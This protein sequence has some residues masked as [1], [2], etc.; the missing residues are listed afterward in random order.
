MSAMKKYIVL[1]SLF[2]L[3]FLLGG[4]RE[5]VFEEEVAVDDFSVDH[6]FSL[7]EG[8]STY[9]IELRV[10][11]DV[12]MGYKKRIGDR[13][14]GDI[15]SPSGKKY[16]RSKAMSFPTKD[17]V[18]SSKVTLLSFSDIAYEEG[19]FNLHVEKKAT[20]I[21]FDEATFTVKK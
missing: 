2:L 20:R 3:L 7:P 14:E 4:C 21:K 5:T 12:Y 19:E 18:I 10:R 13:L 1:S 11:Y 17:T 6:S 16:H 9:D 15:I 8:S